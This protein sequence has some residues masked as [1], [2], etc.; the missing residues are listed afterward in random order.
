V[1]TAFGMTFERHI[2]LRAPHCATI[3]VNLNKEVG[4]TSAKGLT[5]A[6]L[7]ALLSI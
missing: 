1:V 7:G 6:I 3:E 5:F 4:S 2:E